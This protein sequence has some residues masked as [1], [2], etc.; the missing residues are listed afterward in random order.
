MYREQFAKARIPAPFFTV[1]YLRDRDT[2]LPHDGHPN[3]KGHAML[4]DQY[5]NTMIELGW[6][7]ARP[8]HVTGVSG[9]GLFA[10]NAKD[11]PERKV[12]HQEGYAND[13]PQA[14]GFDQFDATEARAVLGGVLREENDPVTGLAVYPWASVRAGFLLRSPDATQTQLKAVIDVPDRAE[15]FPL[16]IKLDLHGLAS[17]SVTVTTP[18]EQIL[19]VNVPESARGLY[20]LEVLFESDHYFAMI[21]DHRMKVFR[22]IRIGWE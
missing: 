12:R 17:E 19:T 8:I 2:A 18:G 20:A 7:N 1:T 11:N 13:L 22:F 14:I 16:T 10:L 6:L 5:L 15:L 9:R 21:D 4:R 3:K